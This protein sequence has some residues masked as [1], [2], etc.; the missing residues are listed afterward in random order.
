MGDSQRTSDLRSVNAPR[1][2]ASRRVSL[3][4]FLGI[5]RPVSAVNDGSDL[6]V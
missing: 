1:V 3:R 2:V 5:F 6:S 4:V